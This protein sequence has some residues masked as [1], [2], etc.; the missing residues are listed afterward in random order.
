MLH[1][2][3]KQP[4]RD[5]ICLISC[6]GHA[7]TRQRSMSAASWNITVALQKTIM[8][9][10]AVKNEGGLIYSKDTTCGIRLLKAVQKGYSRDI[11]VCA[12]IRRCF[13]QNPDDLAENFSLSCL[14]IFSPT[15]QRTFE[16]TVSG[17]R[18][19]A[20]EESKLNQCA[21]R[22]ETPASSESGRGT[23]HEQLSVTM[24]QECQLTGLYTVL[25]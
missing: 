20:K 18:Y 22:N 8:K 10:I 1:S 14:L 5:F 9:N 3:R 12:C 11:S 17:A 23:V 25:I 7:S 13:S 4:E 19:A 21:H 6:T 2:P 24:D 16:L 15:Y